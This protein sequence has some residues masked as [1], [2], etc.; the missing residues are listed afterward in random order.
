MKFTLFNNSIELWLTHHRFYALSWKRR[1][2][3]RSLLQLTEI[4]IFPD[5]AYARIVWS[6]QGIRQN[7]AIDKRPRKVVE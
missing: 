3:Q 1:N 2:F 6:T 4:L 5:S 7:F